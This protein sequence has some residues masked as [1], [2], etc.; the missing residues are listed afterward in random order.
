MTGRA[1]QPCGSVQACGLLRGRRT[2]DVCVR[3]Y[4]A[5]PHGPPEAIGDDGHEM[6][7]VPGGG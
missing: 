6:S 5:I 1:R 4:S 2:R 7:G 3:K